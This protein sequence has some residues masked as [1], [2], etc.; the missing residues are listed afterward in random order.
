M[1]TKAY[2][3][4]GLLVASG[5]LVSGLL[6]N[7]YSDVKQG[8]GKD[9]VAVATFAGGCFWCMEHPYDELEGVVSTTVGYTGGHKEDPTY[10]QVSAGWTGHTEAVQVVYNPQKVSYEKLLEVFWRNIDPLT[11]D[12]QF[13]DKGS[14]Y[15]TGIFYDNENQKR[16]AEQS[17]KALEESKRFDQPIVTEITPASEFYRAEDYHQNY[18]KTHPYRYKF[19]RFACGRD[20]RLNELWGPTLEKK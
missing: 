13:C 10:A 16:L 12:R 3:F 15:R 11:K 2:T 17:K 19:Y 7:A 4:M 18:Y 1:V 14:Q 6:T 9:E 5:L 20:R 8:V